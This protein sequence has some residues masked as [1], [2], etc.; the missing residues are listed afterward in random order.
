MGQAKTGELKRAARQFG[1]TSAGLRRN[2]RKSASPARVGA[3][4]VRQ[5]AGRSFGGGGG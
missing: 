5:H 2:G 4:K 1:V 3:V